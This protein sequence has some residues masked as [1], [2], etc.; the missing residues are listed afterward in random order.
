MVVE[1]V[2]DL[3]DS[4]VA[5]RLAPP[6]A[7]LPTHEL[8][9]GR[10][11]FAFKRWAGNRSI[12]DAQFQAERQRI[13]K[14]VDQ[15]N[16]DSAGIPVLIKR[17]RGMEDSSRY[18]SVWMTLDHLRIVNLSFTRIIRL[19]S[20][21]TIP[22]GKAST[23]NV[24]PS[25]E[26]TAAVRGPYEEACDQLLATTAA[27]PDLNTR[28]RYAHPWFGEMNAAAW[29]ALAGGHMRIHRGQTERILEGLRASDART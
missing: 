27:V 24:K 17:C 20:E 13:R 21:G 29:H 25:S 9:I 12:F 26:A 19:L 18:W 16:P 8:Y 22:E 7:G 3:I 15:C 1:K 11:I 4:N 6:G 5:P 28:A 10:V 23:A 2:V 14:L